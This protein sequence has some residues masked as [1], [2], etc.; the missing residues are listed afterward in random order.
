[1]LV[2]MLLAMQAEEVI[3]RAVELRPANPWVEVFSA[4]CGRQR[5]EVRRPMRPLQT[6]SRVLLNGRA[7]RGD[8]SPLELELGEA[9]AA[10]R[11][12]FGCSQNG[13][14]MQLSWVSGLV[15][16]HGQVRY[17]AGSAEF[18]QG[19]LVRSLSEEANEET[20]W[21]R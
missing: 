2:S 14:T 13:E 17:R 6:G 12:S 15:G 9:G 8:V 4:S 20:F 3:V 11:M 1:M 5:L 21:Y 10:Y 19:A 16:E 18:R 7:A